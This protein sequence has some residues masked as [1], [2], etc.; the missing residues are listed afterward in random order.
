VIDV[1]AV[2]A[3][4]HVFGIFI[5]PHWAFPKTLSSYKNIREFSEFGAQK[6]KV[7]QLNFT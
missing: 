5:Y 2:N 6:I 3:I 7:R 4:T 1:I